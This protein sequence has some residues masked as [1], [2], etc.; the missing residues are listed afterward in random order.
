MHCA[1]FDLSCEI[2]YICLLGKA[3]TKHET[4]KALNKASKALRRCRC[5]LGWPCR[6][7]YALYG[8]TFVGKQRHMSMQ[9]SCKR[10]RA[11]NGCQPCLSLSEACV[12]S[13]QASLLRYVNPIIHLLLLQTPL[14]QDATN[15][16][17]DIQPAALAQSPADCDNEENDLLSQLEMP[18]DAHASVM[19]LR[20]SLY[21][22]PAAAAAAAIA[23]S[24]TRHA[25]RS[26]PA[27]GPS[28]AAAAAAQAAAAAATSAA[29]LPPLLLKSQLYTVL[30]DRTAADR[31][32]ENL[33]RQGKVRLFK[34]AI[35]AALRTMQ[36]RK[37]W[38]RLQVWCWHAFCMSI[39]H[40]VGACAHLFHS[41][42]RHCLCLCCVLCAIF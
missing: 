35:G 24:Q 10:R 22:D 7:V 19:L 38:S 40:V 26:K 20:S 6:Q 21:P 37:R 1:T 33:R 9:G 12:L 23:A 14:L 32:V 42:Y 17:T 11:V 39:K 30:N 18:S 5:E 31:D 13:A 41:V 34:L 28:K 8:A 4:Q 25:K 27:A 3:S 29:A 15:A 2:L 16:A 36:L